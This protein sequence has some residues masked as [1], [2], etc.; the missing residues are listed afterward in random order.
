MESE[1]WKLNGDCG[2]GVDDAICGAVAVDCDIE[3]HANDKIKVGNDWYSQATGSET[4]RRCD[5]INHTLHLS[6]TLSLLAHRSP[7]ASPAVGHRFVPLLW[8]ARFLSTHPH[9]FLLTHPGRQRIE[10]PTP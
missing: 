4:Y 8:M 1:I 7:A 3:S 5:D 10:Y 2:G 6:S 9:G